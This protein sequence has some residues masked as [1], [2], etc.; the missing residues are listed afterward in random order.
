MQQNSRVRSFTTA[1]SVV[2][3]AIL[4]L[5]GRPAFAQSDEGIALGAS[6]PS[7]VVTDAAGH[8]VAVTPTPGRPMLIEFWATW[9]EFCERL[10]PTMKSVYG[11]Y[12]GKV[13]FAAIAVNVNQSPSRVERHVNERALAYP[14]YYDA[15]GRAT[16]AYDVAAT[17]FVVIIDRK[18]K[19]AYTGVGDKQDLDAAIRRVL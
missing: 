17:S 8:S 6:A 12:G 13:Q 16:A 1:V 19:V 3:A 4:I 14:V 11:K 7:V 10:E 15:S 2:C 18:G 9:C 5:A